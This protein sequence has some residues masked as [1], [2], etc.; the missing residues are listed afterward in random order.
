LK[1]SASP[2]EQAEI[3]QQRKRL[4]TEG[5]SFVYQS[6]A[7]DPTL[8]DA[9]RSHGFEVRAIFI[10]KEHPDL[11]AARIFS[12]ASRGGLFG[13]VAGSSP[14]PPTQ[15]PLPERGNRARVIGV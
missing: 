12:R 13:P 3:E 6:P 7:V 8:V 14:T 10:V 1:A 11:N 2:L 5:K 4:L 15:G 9:A